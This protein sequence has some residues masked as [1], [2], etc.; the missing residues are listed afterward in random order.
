MALRSIRIWPDPCLTQAALPVAP[1]DGD[2]PSLVR[3]LFDTMYASDGI[4]LAANQIGVAKRVL[5]IDLDPTHRSAKDPETA[6]ELASWRFT[7]P[8][9]LVNPEIIDR[10]GSI[11]WQEGCLSVP[12][13]LDNVRR[14]A[15]ITVCAQDA[16]GERIS[17]VAH[18]L[19]AV[20]IQHE[21]D[22]LDGKV[23]IDHLSRLKREMVRR[24]LLRQAKQRKQGH[25][26][27]AS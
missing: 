23:F 5:V 25:G 11:V 3:D 6:Q 1:G 27:A 7:K 15:E 9:A 13:I 19:Y 12:G 21:L 2:I 24:K 8:I 22:H 17:F 20:C 18:G 14:S 26:R 10:R 4:G 16:A